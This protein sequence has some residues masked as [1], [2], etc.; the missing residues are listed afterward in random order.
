MLKSIV[1]ETSKGILITTKLRRI[2]GNHDAILSVFY[3]VC[4]RVS[5][6]V[7]V[8]SFMCVKGGACVLQ[9]ACEVDGLVPGF[10]AYL[11]PCWRQSPSLLCVLQS[12]WLQ[13]SRACPIS[14]SLTGPLGLQTCATEPSLGKFWRFELRPSNFRGR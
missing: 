13:A 4:V 1:T 9:H 14:A 3:F 5:V 12:C 2:S 7:C 6:S 10:A 11:P 8:P